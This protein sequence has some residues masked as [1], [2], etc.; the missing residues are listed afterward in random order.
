MGLDLHDNTPV[1]AHWFCHVAFPRA[2]PFSILLEIFCSIH[3]P[4]CRSLV[5]SA[6]A[7][8]VGACVLKESHQHSPRQKDFLANVAA[9]LPELACLLRLHYC[10]SVATA[11][12][13]CGRWP[14]HRSSIPYNSTPLYC[15]DALHHWKLSVNEKKG[16]CSLTSAI[17]AVLPLAHSHEPSSGG[18]PLLAA[19][20]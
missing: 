1:L 6:N 3:P 11:D 18:A 5:D 15:D 4:I 19:S 17:A 7:F 16:C 14:L 13:R 20:P 10:C 2:L 9:F 8:F 12:G